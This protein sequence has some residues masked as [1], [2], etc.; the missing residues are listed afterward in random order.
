[1]LRFVDRRTSALLKHLNSEEDLPAEI[2]P[3]GEVAIGGHRVGRLEG[4]VF[5]P[6]PTAEA[7]AGRA[8]R[9]AALKS[10]MPIIERRLAAIASASDADLSFDAAKA[11]IDHAGAPVAKLS[12]GADWL[13]PAIE[14][15]GA[16]D[17]TGASRE[18]A[19]A[20]LAGWFGDHSRIVLA[21]L[22]QLAELLEG[23]TLKGAAR[24]TAYQLLQNGAAFDRRSDGGSRSVLLLSPED[25]A[26]LNAAGVKSGRVAAWL[27]ALLKPAPAALALAL[28]TVHAQLSA[29][30]ALSQS[31]F[32]LKEPWPDVLL[33]TAGY[34][35]LGPRAVRAD[36]AERLVV[37]LG[38]IRRGSE[39]SAFGVP[40][41]L[42]AHIGC[43]S[44]E[45]PA[46]LRSLGLKPAERD[47]ATGAVKLWRFA[48][49]R[50]QSGRTDAAAPSTGPFAVLADLVA[51]SQQRQRRRRKPRPN[52]APG[53]AVAPKT[54]S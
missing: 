8:L 14:L 46:V 7:L 52:P 45:L 11:Q 16:R 53:A 48:A 3:S 1:M 6:D 21:A 13:A 32:T 30:P 33:W 19:Q 29:R 22:H 26:A 31:S 39:T 35:R 9:G 47:R 34:L 25:R 2:G 28:R 49:I 27:P 43:P 42:A 41:E 50:A 37:F 10:L 17:A 36:L 40:P 12:P 20:R 24:G 4:L 38:R 54:A 44:A 23:D 18:A 15:I 51:P 5:T